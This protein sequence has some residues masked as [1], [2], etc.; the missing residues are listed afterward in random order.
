MSPISCFSDFARKKLSN[1][2][3][4]SFQLV[5]GFLYVFEL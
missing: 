4:K 3:K 1:R 5:E 2:A